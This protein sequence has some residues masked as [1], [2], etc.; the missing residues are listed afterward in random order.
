MAHDPPHAAVLSTLSSIFWR[1]VGDRA[2]VRVQLPLVVG[3]LSVPEPDIAIVAGGDADY[4]H[5]HPT[6]ALLVVEV[7]DSS[8]AQDRLTKAAIYARGGVSEYVIV[9]LRDDTIEAWATGSTVATR[10][11]QWCAAAR[12]GGWGNV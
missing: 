6:T 2:S 12:R 8:V 7:A 4:F 9:N 5:A 1:R 10:G 3:G 11:Y